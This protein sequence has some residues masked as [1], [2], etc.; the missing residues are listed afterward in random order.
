VRTFQG[1]LICELSALGELDAYAALF[2]RALRTMHARRCAKVVVKKPA[3]MREFGLTARQFNAL[4]KTLDGIHASYR[5]RLPQLI[6]EDRN[7][8]A[9]LK[10]R[11]ARTDDRSNVHQ[12]KRRIARIAERLKARQAEQSA[13]AVRIAFGTKKLFRAQYALEESGFAD[14][15][16]WRSAWREA[17]SDQFF[18]LGSKDETAGCQGCVIEHLGQNRFGLRL[19]LPG[20]Q[21]RYVWLETRLAYG[22]EHVLNALAVKQAISY[23]FLRDAKGWRVFIST[24]PIAVEQKTDRRIGTLGIDLNADHLAASLTDRFGNLV[25][26]ERIPLVT[27]GCSKAQAAARTGDAVKRVIEI[28]RRAEVPIVIEALDFAKKKTAMREQGRR[29][30]RMLSALSYAKIRTTLAARAYDVGLRV[31]TVKPQFSSV[32]GRHKFSRRYGISGHLAA[33]LVL[34]RRAR[35]FSERVSRH[36]QVALVVP[37]RT[38]QR[39]VWSSWARVAKEEKRRMHLARRSSQDDPELAPGCVTQRKPLQR[40]TSRRRRDSGARIVVSTV[41]TASL[42]A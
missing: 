42:L 10:R 12:V 33:A 28:A 32:I 35:G 2:G 31:K 19:R 30:S 21:R 7:R 20:T 11:L 29:Y 34:A 18:V 14:H 38:R 13:G 8:L 25:E 37:V 15:A 26:H 39:H 36:G 22:A 27:Y 40:P 9:S 1:R 4:A 6:D 16:A 17:R 5:E 24:L 41:R 3:F 23:R